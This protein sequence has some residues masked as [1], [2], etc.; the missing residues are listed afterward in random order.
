MVLSMLINSPDKC[1]CISVLNYILYKS[2][3]Y[4]YFNDPMHK[5]AHYGIS[6]FYNFLMSVLNDQDTFSTL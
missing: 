3:N 1:L 2:T 6:N 5:G 4:L